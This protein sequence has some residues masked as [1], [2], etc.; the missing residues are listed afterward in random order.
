MLPYA[1]ESSRSVFGKNKCKIYVIKLEMLW[2]VF[3]ISCTKSNGIHRMKFLWAFAY[4]LFVRLFH[5]CTKAVLS[6][7][8]LIEIFSI[9]QLLRDTFLA[10]HALKVI[11]YIE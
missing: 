6:A 9:S 10:F 3:G 2:Y 11:E 8:L 5:Q 4:L 7:L 1:F